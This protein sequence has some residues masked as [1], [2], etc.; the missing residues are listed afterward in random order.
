MFIHSHH[1]D[2]HLLYLWSIFN[3]IKL[4]S[5]EFLFTSSRMMNTVIVGDEELEEKLTMHF[6]SLYLILLS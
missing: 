6:Q 4:I 3:F 2:F 1:K 5:S